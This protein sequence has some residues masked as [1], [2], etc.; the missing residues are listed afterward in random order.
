MEVRFSGNPCQ[1]WV[2]CRLAGLLQK[3]LQVRLGGLPLAS[4]LTACRPL[5]T[6]GTQKAQPYRIGRT[7]FLNQIHARSNGLLMDDCSP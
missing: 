3:L 7:A 1:H 2:W 5:D 6:T 4:P